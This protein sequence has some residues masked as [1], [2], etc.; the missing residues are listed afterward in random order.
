M[1]RFWT[2]SIVLFLLKTQPFGNWIF[3]RLQ[4]IPSQLGPIDRASPYFRTPAPT[5]D[6]INKPSTAQNPKRAKTE[7]QNIKTSTRLRLSTRELSEYKS[8][9]DRQM[10]PTQQKNSHFPNHSTLD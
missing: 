3:L 9:L 8:S 7:H 1:S 4:V 5:Q 10:V 2:L 6:S